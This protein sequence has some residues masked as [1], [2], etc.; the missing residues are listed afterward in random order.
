MEKLFHRNET[1]NNE[2]VSKLF[3]GIVLFVFLVWIFCW[4]GIFDFDM[5]IASI[6]ACIS[7]LLLLIPFVLI[8]LIHFNSHAMKYILIL[9]LSLC[10][11]ICYYIFTFQM[12]IMLI[13]PSLVA[14]LYMNKRLLYFSGI[15][16]F[17]IIAAAHIV[18]SFYVLQPWLEPFTGLKNVIRFDLIPRIMQLGVCF[19]L[20]LALMNRMLDYMQ[21]L[22][23]INDELII[24]A[25]FDK[26]NPN[27]ERKEL[28]S[29]LSLLTDREKEIFIQ[30]LQG[31][32]N[33]QIAERLCLSNGT[34]KNY[35]SS[36]YDKIGI[37]ERNYLI[38]RFG[39]ILAYYD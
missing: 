13:L 10:M 32:T 1:E 12:V 9:D 15:V 4:G 3:V 16:N 11:G 36:I 22:E 8:Y 30:M 28:D 31:K 6:F 27:A 17:V 5:Q 7:T 35:V 26:E 24:E 18:S 38:L 29:Y 19:A 37:K 21:Q 2:M 39:H 25:G 23:S 14:M 34:V 20:L 33:M